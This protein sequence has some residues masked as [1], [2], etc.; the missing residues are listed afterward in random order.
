MP[1][2]SRTERL[3]VAKPRGKA[4][5]R[6]AR[7]RPARAP[8]KLRAAHGAGLSR[9]LSILALCL[10]VSLGLVVVLATGGRGERLAHA[11]RT[12]A[13]THLASIG[14]RL[15][16][17]HLQGASPAA[18]ADILHAAAIPLG[19]PIFDVDLDAI[20]QRVERVGWVER[21]RVIRLLPDTLVV[22]VDERPLIAVWEHAGRA[23]VIASNGAVM[24]KVDPARFTSLPLIVGEDANLD[25][26][27]ILKLVL[28]RQRLAQRLD[29]LVRVDTRRWDIRLKD[30]CLIS[31]PAAGDDEALARLDQLDRR[32]RL[33]ELGFARIDLRDPEMVV[34]RP[35]GAVAPVSTSAGV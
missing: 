27:R 18:Q 8:S 34:V 3:V 32:T 29:A 17:V 23:M 20:R 35:R 1:A 22:S 7:A 11:V 10:V 5:P 16:G 30:G 2:A 14:F 12:A 33:L 28:G 21:A 15:G 4:A 31:L 6:S 25:A 9:A 26:A 13:D 19:A 24:T